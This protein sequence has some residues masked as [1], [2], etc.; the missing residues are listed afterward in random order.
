MISKEVHERMCYSRLFVVKALGV[1]ITS[2]RN[3][4]LGSRYYISS[5]FESFILNFG[6]I[7]LSKKKNHL[8]CVM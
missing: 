8:S 1:L 7:L 3:A 4:V 6:V 5:P 2:E